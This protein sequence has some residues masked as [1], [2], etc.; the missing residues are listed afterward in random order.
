MKDG[1]YFV[2]FRSNSQDFGNGTVIVKDNI[3]NGG[4][5]AY[6]YRGKVNGIQTTLTIE[7]HDK[8]ATSVFGDIDKF[9]L[10]LNIAESGRDYVLAGHVEGIQQM[11]ITINAKFIGE[12]IN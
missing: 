7:R 10:I 5:F 8:S 9:N 12:V 3:V 11:K 6:L 4:D 2:R 1:I